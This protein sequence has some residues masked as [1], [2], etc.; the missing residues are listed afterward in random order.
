MPSDPGF[1]QAAAIL[2]RPFVTITLVAVKGEAPASPGAKA[3]VT[4]Q[5][6]HHG[7]VGGG[8]VEARAIIHAIEQLRA[9]KA[10]ELVTWNLQ[11]DIGM[12]CGGEVTFLF[13]T[14]V[15]Q[16][17]ALF[18]AGHVA[19]AL[20]RI[21]AE[22]PYQVTCIDS[23]PEWLE[24]LPPGIA[25]H[26]REPATEVRTFDA[27]T[28][29]IVMT[30]GHATDVPILE[31]IYRHFPNA[32]YIGAIGSEVK[33]LKLKAE[34]RQRGIAPESLRCPI[35]LPIG[36]NHPGEIAVSIAAE[37]LKSR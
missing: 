25:R 31:E 20:T 16:E 28:L 32:P 7:T 33:A 3:I 36:G 15:T 37:L 9:P 12:T 27:R 8:K 18:G 14:H 22:L 35:G 11:K 30:Q 26:S 10:P 23:R 6:L 21:L 4:A 17:I 29:F 13:E 5:G 1:F 19:Q 24:K 34:L 2:S